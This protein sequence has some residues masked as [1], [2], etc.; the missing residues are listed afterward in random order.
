MLQF[1]QM[2]GVREDP[3]PL[4]DVVEG[5]RIRLDAV[6][7]IAGQ[8]QARTDEPGLKRAVV[9]LYFSN[10]GFNLGCTEHSFWD[11][12]AFGGEAALVEACNNWTCD[13][14]GPAV[15]KASAGFDR[16]STH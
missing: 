1:G 4:E 11:P 14:M 2:Q 9:F 3:V 10:M 13:T 8:A 16:V 15:M 5:T 12:T 7:D 6:R